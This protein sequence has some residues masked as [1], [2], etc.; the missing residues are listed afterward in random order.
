MENQ[1]AKNIGLLYRIKLTSDKNSIPALYLHYSYIHTYLNYAKLSWDSTNRINLKKLLSQQK[2]S[3]RIINNR[4]RFDHTKELFKLQ[5]N[6]LHLQ[7]Q[8]LKSR[9]FH[10]PNEK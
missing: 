5:K 7:I 9:N 1:V 2:H 10:V 8:Q 6:I 4:I 3:V